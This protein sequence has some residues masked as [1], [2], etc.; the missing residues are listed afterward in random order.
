M[1]KPIAANESQTH[2]KR[3]RRNAAQSHTPVP[4]RILLLVPFR[5]E[6][7]APPSSTTPNDK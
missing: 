6:W 2:G 5:A 4:L 1:D 7:R 3:R